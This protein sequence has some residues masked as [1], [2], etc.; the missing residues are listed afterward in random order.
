VRGASEKGG[1]GA[2][3]EIIYD[4]AQRGKST[5]KGLITVSAISIVG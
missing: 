3:C 4:V 2:I 5:D 1:E